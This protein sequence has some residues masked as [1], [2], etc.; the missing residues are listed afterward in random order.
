MLEGAPVTR[1]IL[2]AIGLSS[3][4]GF[5]LGNNAEKLLGVFSNLLLKGSHELVP[6]GYLTYHYASVERI[7]GSEQL[8]ARNLVASALIMYEL[9]LR[10][11]VEGP[12]T[13]IRAT[14][15]ELLF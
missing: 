11:L 10:V 1:S 8:L 2:I 5:Q 7:I 9:M 13:A 12:E 4:V 6:F 3:L 15:A 14:T